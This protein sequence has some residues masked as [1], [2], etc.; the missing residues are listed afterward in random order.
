M[1][2]KKRS[3]FSFENPSMKFD[4]QDLWEKKDNEMG[5]EEM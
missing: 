2:F 4:R 5:S 3:T 1:F